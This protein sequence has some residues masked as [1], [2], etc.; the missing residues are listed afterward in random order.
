MES[1]ELIKKI[2]ELKNMGGHPRFYELLL[3][4]AEL[5]ARKNHDYAKDKDPLSNLKMCESFGI[6]PFQGILVRLSDKWSRITQLSKKQA[7]VKDESILDTLMDMA[8]Y[9]LLAI[10]VKEEEQD[11]AK[12][13]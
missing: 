8:V 2:T 9:S 12:T 5:H 10:I 13:H 7:M 3:Q 6:T 11:A 4:I 1:K